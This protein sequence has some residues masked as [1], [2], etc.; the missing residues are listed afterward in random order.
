[1]RDTWLRLAGVAVL[2][3]ASFA[4]SWRLSRAS[5]HEDVRGALELVRT[6]RDNTVCAEEGGCLAGGAD[7]TLFVFFSGQDCSVSLFDT[8]VLDSVY[9]ANP[10][11]RVDVV[12][13]VYDL[14]AEE[15]QAFARS[16]GISYPV[17]V[18]PERLERFVHNPRP[19]ATNKPAKLLVDRDGRVLASYTSRTTVAWHHVDAARMLGNVP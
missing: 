17:Y 15:A 14:S 3:A 10:R 2:S 9:R 6:D 5:W 11:S 1:M 8:V 7:Y 4:G 19:A 16:S 13:V 12:G 18:R